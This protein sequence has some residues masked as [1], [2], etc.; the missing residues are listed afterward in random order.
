MKKDNVTPRDYEKLGRAIE[1]A[2]INDYINLLGNTRKQMVSGF[3]RGVATGFGT[4]V[5][6]TLV[7]ALVIWILGLLGGLPFIGDYLKGAGDAITK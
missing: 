1:A 5:G 6:A 2:L 4:V 7:V 3:L